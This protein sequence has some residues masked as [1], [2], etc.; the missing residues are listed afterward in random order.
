M[1]KTLRRQRDGDG[2]QCWTRTD[3]D[4]AALG[5]CRTPT[6]LRRERPTR[7]PMSM[8]RTERPSDRCSIASAACLHVDGYEGYKLL[9][10]CCSA[11]LLLEPLRGVS[12]ERTGAL[13]PTAKEAPSRI[14]AFYR[15]ESTIRGRSAEERPCVRKHGA[16]SS[17]PS[18][19]GCA[20]S[21]P[22]SAGRASSPRRG[23]SR[24]RHQPHHQRP[25]VGRIDELLL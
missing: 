18:N 13:V 14:A 4:Q 12:F 10:K 11:R 24:Q 7:C 22:S 3:Q 21:S 1:A 20:R 9:T 23:Y 19:A 16:P 5:L 8:H 2:A 6:S 25:P 15:I 17:R